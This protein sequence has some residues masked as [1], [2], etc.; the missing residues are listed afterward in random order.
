MPFV[1]KRRSRLIVRFTIQDPRRFPPAF[2]LL[3]AHLAMAAPYFLSRIN[4]RDCSDPVAVGVTAGEAAVG[5]EN[6]MTH[7]FGELVV[8]F[9]RGV[10]WSIY[11]KD[12]GVVQLPGTPLFAQVRQ[13]SSSAWTTCLP[14]CHTD[15]VFRRML[16]YPRIWQRSSS[17]VHATLFASF[18]W[19]CGRASI[20]STS[21][22]SVGWK[23]VS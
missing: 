10:S 6:T 23:P 4:I 5:R 8:F 11:D 20:W 1:R 16:Y 17:R 12:D 22:C 15:F 18:P 14:S 21:L 13:G 19:A 9:Y 3:R 2:F 7:L